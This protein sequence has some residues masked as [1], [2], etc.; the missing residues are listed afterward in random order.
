MI[1]TGFVGAGVVSGAVIGAGEAG[2][3]R[4]DV[5]GAVEMGIEVAGIDVTKT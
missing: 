2:V 4:P 3:V 5:T 1:G